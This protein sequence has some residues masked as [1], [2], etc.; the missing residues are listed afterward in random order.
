[1]KTRQL[2]IH[3]ENI[4]PIIKK[5]L[6]SDQDIFIRELVSN[7][8]DALHKIKIISEQQATPLKQDELTISIQINAD[9][10]TLTIS[11]TGIGMT[12]DEV[13]K[14][15]A[16][17][18]FSGA[19]EFAKTYAKKDPHDSIIGHFG[20]GFY[21]AYMVASLVEIDTL[22]FQHAAAPALW[23]CDG[24]SSYTIEEG[25]RATR[26]TTI[27]LHIQE[28]SLSFLEESTLL[29]CL[30]KYCQFF[31]YPIYLNGKSL[32]N[33]LPLW[34]R[35]PSE[36]T[37]QDYL[38]LYRKLNPM[39]PDPLFWIHLNVDYPFH[40]QGV[41]Y[42]PKEKKRWE[43]QHSIHLYCNKV[44]VSDHC[45]DILPDYL[46]MLKGV[47]DSPDIP[48]NVS[49]SYLQ[50]D[51]NVKQ[52][53]THIAKKIADRL[54]QLFTT[55]R[56]RYESVWAD[57]EPIVK[58]GILQDKK[59]ADKTEDILLFTSNRRPFTTLKE[60]QERNPDSPCFYSQTK[61]QGPLV[62][63]YEE[64][65]I[66]ILWALSPMDIPLIQNLEIHHK[67]SLQR[68]DGKLDQALLDPTRESTLLDQ[69]GT[70]RS[71]RLQKTLEALLGE[72]GLKIEVKSL[73]SDKLPAFFL[74]DE[75]ER[76]MRDYMTLVQPTSLSSHEPQ[77]TFIAN[78]NSPLI[79]AL[80][81]LSKSTTHR[82]FAEGLAKAVYDLSLIGQKE[83]S[84]EKL[85]QAIQRQ[86]QTLEEI[87][88][89]L[90]DHV[91]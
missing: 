84:P 24:S 66:E 23:K 74:I 34:I 28:E 41:L 59:F 73:A 48:L 18:A 8:S 68:L 5:W 60:Y 44:F 58:L 85:D 82:N 91:S 39:D 53:S 36:C 71:A 76:R 61:Q 40:L 21:S 33:A 56:P 32:N 54:N 15:I 89:A 75:K 9:Q 62:Q 51:K 90:K 47:L 13:E 63:L 46:T 35:P 78:S 87:A 10:K 79:L 27:T 42:F 7:A 69:E 45:K 2:S 12:A 77:R 50:L 3:S 16:Q 65:N 64:K 43:E 83:L 70:T 55:D 38:S 80:E 57:L 29:A 37:D 19:E 6:Y 72:P 25:T 4:L 14:Y 81:K 26:G 49:R 52:L 1:M 67:Y 17:I 22:S 30:K 86:S 11:D 20:L 31:P 88:V